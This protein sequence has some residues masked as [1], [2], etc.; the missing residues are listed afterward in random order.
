MVQIKIALVVTLMRYITDT[1]ILLRI[2]VALA[3]KITM[4]MG[5]F[6]VNNVNIFA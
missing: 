4:M 6:F 2:I 3:Y 1:K 5:Q